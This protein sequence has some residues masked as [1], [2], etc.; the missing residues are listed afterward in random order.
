M[1]LAIYVQTEFSPK[2]NETDGIIHFTERETY[3]KFSNLKLQL[4]NKWQSHI[5]P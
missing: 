4:Q 5:M 2:L 1:S 3:L